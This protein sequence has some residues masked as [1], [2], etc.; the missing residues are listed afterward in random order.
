MGG[1]EWAY[2]ASA[3][4]SPTSSRPSPPPGQRAPSLQHLQH[5]FGRAAERGFV[6]RDDDRPFDDDG[7]FAI[8]AMSWSSDSLAGSMPASAASFLRMSARAGISNC[9]SS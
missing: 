5:L 3:L 2:R 7:C 9:P 4:E 1:C 8:A 6:A